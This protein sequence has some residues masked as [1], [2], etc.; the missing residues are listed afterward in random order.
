MN[1]T[2]TSDHA[3]ALHHAQDAVDAEPGVPEAGVVHARLASPASWAHSDDIA[4]LMQAQSFEEEASCF[5]RVIG[6]SLNAIDG[7]DVEAFKSRFV[8]A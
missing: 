3:S 4:S 7:E 8:P 2:R 1:S 6:E 5:V